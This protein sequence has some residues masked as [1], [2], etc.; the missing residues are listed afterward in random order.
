M[1]LPHKRLA[2]ISSNMTILHLPYISNRKT[3]AMKQFFTTLICTF[4]FIAFAQQDVDTFIT[5]PGCEDA[6]D[7]EDCFFEKVYLHIVDS[8]ELLSNLVEKDSF[9]FEA[10]VI[11]GI[12]GSVYAVE[13][14]KPV[15]PAF[16]EE[17]VRVIESLPR[18]QP[19]VKDGKNISLQVTIPIHY[20]TDDKDKVLKYAYVEKKPVFPGCEDEDSEDDKLTCFNQKMMSHVAKNFKFPDEARRDKAEGVTVATFIIERDGSVSGVRILR[21]VH[22]ALDAETIRVM[23]LLP[24]FTPATQ[25]GKPVRMQYNMPINAKIN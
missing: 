22:P 20:K 15:D 4:S 13:V 1:Y 17:A 12:D 2:P 24:T 21:S 5:Y 18:V 7:L 9:T 3:I 6:S 19:A 8:S 10:D 16:D 23:E 14:V 25:R 11:F